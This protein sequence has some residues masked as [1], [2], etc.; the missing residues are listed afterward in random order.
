MDLKPNGRNVLVTDENKDE[1]IQLIAEYRLTTSIKP[2]L[3]AF[4]EGF[5]EI[6]PK[7]HISIVSLLKHSFSLNNSLIWLP[8]QR[9]GSRAPDLWNTRDRCGRLAI[10]YG[11]SWL[12]CLRCSDCMVVACSQVVL[13]SG[14]SQGS[15][16]CNGHGQSPAWWICGASGAFPWELSY[17]YLLRVP[18][19]MDGVQRFSIHKDPGPMNRLPQAHTCFNQSESTCEPMQHFSDSSPQSICR[20]TPRMKCCDNNSCWPSTRAEKVLDLRDIRTLVIRM[21]RT[22]DEKRRRICILQFTGVSTSLRLITPTP[23]R[24]D[25]AVCGAVMKACRVHALARHRSRTRTPRISSRQ[26][27]SVNGVASLD[28]TATKTTPDRRHIALVLFVG[29]VGYAVY[30]RETLLHVGCAAARV[31]RIATAT[32]QGAWD[33]HNTFKRTYLTKEEQLEAYSQCHTRSA[34]RV[35]KALL[36]N[37][38]IFIKLVSHSVIPLIGSVYFLIG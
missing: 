22:E 21:N 37:G 24:L 17:R 26:P 16:F 14:S 36:A 29:G 23:T 8:V 10:G 11:V 34:Q 9:E 19:G 30:H 25:S 5:Y 35:L 3:D 1:Y 38:G 15:Q 18:Q 13:Q 7:E 27:F 33:Y 2:Q 32:F 28:R 31:T 12:Q 4:L 6:V 20:S